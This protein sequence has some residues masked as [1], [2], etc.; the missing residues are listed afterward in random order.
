MTMMSEP[1]APSEDDARIA[2]KS[3]RQLAML[4]VSERPTIQLPGAAPGEVPETIVLPKGA[5][6]LLMQVLAE[7]GKGNAVTLM[8]IHAQLTTQ[9]AAELLGV[10]RPFIVK[11]IREGKLG[12]QMVGAARR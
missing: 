6:Q 2:K 1:V 12:Y 11:E 3:S 10:S 5:V 8:P 4:S 7:M 9:Q